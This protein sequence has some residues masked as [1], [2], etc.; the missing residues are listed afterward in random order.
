M[1]MV[2]RYMVKRLCVASTLV[3][4]GLCAPVT[5][6]STYNHLSGIAIYSDLVWPALYG[7]VPMILY[8]TMPVAVAVAITWCYGDFYSEF[9]LT[10]LQSAGV[11]A[12]STRA[13]ALVVGLFATAIAYAM[14]CSVAPNG[15]KYLQDVL[16]VIQHV[17]NPSLLLPDQFYSADDGRHVI[18]FRKRLSKNRVA[19]VF[20]K[21]TTESGQE[22]ALSAHEGIFD[23]R[24][25][26]SW[27]IL[28][29]GQMQVYTPGDHEVETFA[30]ER[31]TRQTGLAGSSLP[32][33]TWVMEFEL[34]ALEFLKAPIDGL[35]D[36]A[37]AARWLSEAVERFLIPLLTLTHTML[38][39][40]LLAIWG[41]PTGRSPQFLPLIF[42]YCILFPLHLLFVIAAEHVAQYGSGLALAIAA[43][44]FIE[45]STGSYLMMRGQG[46][47]G[48]SRKIA[49]ATL[50]PSAAGRY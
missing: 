13:P 38:G 47:L 30:F 14:S 3:V 36:P 12:L 7:I 48:H 37:A 32:K 24:E 45:F 44:V 10:V 18:Y 2:H 9:T 11:S 35:S 46:K 20:L 34:G 19:D 29:D 31:T 21:E 4:L 1:S 26:Q 6:V 8:H 41:D 42:T 5:L 15:S 40:G 25:D 17:P 49:D 43:A 23:R 33:R 28:L 50:S 16:N 39:L 22:L 27:I